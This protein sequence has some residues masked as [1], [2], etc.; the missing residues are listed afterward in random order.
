MFGYAVDTG[1]L[2]V[3]ARKLADGSNGIETMA[4]PPPAPDAG[5]MT[6]LIAAH[7]AAITGAIATVSENMAEAGQAVSGN[8]AAYANFDDDTADTFGK[9]RDK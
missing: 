5:I 7:L 1:E 8:S 6:G 3:L 9:G 2:G 4:A